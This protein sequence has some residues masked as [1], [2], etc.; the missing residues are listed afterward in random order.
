[1][2]VQILSQIDLVKCFLLNLLYQ[3]KACLKDGNFSL[4]L[5]LAVL[6][7]VFSEEAIERLI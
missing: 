5:I 1:M 2:L 4:F 6:L 7:I 3:T